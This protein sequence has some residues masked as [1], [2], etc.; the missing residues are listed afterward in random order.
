MIGIV[1]PDHLAIHRELLLVIGIVAEQPAQDAGFLGVYGALEGSA[2]DRVVAGEID[3]LDAG[4][5]AFVDD[6]G[7]E[8]AATVQGLG[9]GRHL[10]V[11]ETGAVIGEADA[12]DIGL[13]ALRVVG[14][15]G[16]NIDHGQQLGV[17]KAAIALEQHGSNQRILAL[18][19]RRLHPQQRAAET[20]KRRRQENCQ[21]QKDAAREL[22]G[23]IHIVIA[24]C[25]CPE[26]RHA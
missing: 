16:R 1:E 11:V 6:E 25:P 21:R 8:H 3:G 4:A 17:G 22:G 7:H 15:T 13:D 19:P 10:H 24:F 18:R 9:V 2:V 20:G 12:L 23:N 14:A 5:F 26:N